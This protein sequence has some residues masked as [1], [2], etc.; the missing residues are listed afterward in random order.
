MQKVLSIEIGTMTTKVCEMDYRK[1]NPKIYRSV[2]IDTPKNTIEDGYIRDKE[3]FAGFMRTFLEKNN[4]Q[5]KSAVFTIASSKILSREV[6]IPLV[7][8]NRIE[9]L[10]RSEANEYFPRDISDYIVTYSILEKK[11]EE[12]KI[13]LMAF[14]APSNLITNYYSF[15]KLLG[16]SVAA[17]DYIGNSSYQWLKKIASTET[18]FVLQINE[19]SSIATIMNDGIMVLQRTINYGTNVL[20]EAVIETQLFGVDEMAAATELLQ[21]SELLQPRINM[22]LDEDTIIAMS[23]EDYFRNIQAKQM[24]TESMQLFISN[25]SRIIEYQVTRSHQMNVVSTIREITIT[26]IGSQIKGLDML[27]SNEIALPVKKNLSIN[28]VNMV[29]NQQVTRERIGELVTCLG[30]AMAPVNFI[31]DDMA[32]AVEKKDFWKVYAGV[33]LAS[34]IGSIAFVVFSFNNYNSAVKDRERLQQGID[35]MSYIDEKYNQYIRIQSIRDSLVDMYYSTY[36]PNENFNAILKELEDKLPASTIISSLD[37]T[38]S[39][40]KLTCAVHN[41]EAAGQLMLQV[42]KIP[43]FSEITTTGIT[44]ELNADN[45]TSVVRFTINCKYVQEPVAGG[46][47]Q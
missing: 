15:A 23:G 5:T 40:L 29:G 31:P 12:K 38:Q 20:A 36:R 10:V 42:L 13:L 30:A 2:I 14:A 3:T 22:N 17:I 39:E 25:L 27:I 46:E 9:S 34:L 45:G 43:Y 32:G 7:K 4:F 1:K 33:L 18:T 6:T 37:S 11:Q 19:D 44:E 35:E 24:I 21:K 8:D 47:L 26:G 16:L 41:K 28:N